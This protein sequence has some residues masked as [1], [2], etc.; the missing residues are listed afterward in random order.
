MRAGRPR[1]VIARRGL[2]LLAAFGFA[3]PAQAGADDI[4][5]L[6]EAHWSGLAAAH[7]RLT[8]HREPGAYRDEIAIV[9]EGLPRLWSKFR[10]TGVSSGRLTAAGPAP[11]RFDADYDLR[12]RKARRLRMV[13]VARSGTIVAERGADDTS[14]KTQLAE[15]FRTSVVDP[16]SALSAIQAALRRGETRFSVPVYDGAR[17]FDA[18]VE[19]QPRDPA[20][21]GARLAMTLKAIAGFKGESSDEGDPDDAP[22]PASLT[23]SDDERLLPLAMT[24]TIWY[25]PLDV[26]LVRTCA[27]AA[28]CSW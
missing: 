19:R 28:E 14:R 7:I 16:L 24:V 27:T 25:L 4:V 23:L 9:A 15:E 11:A 3:W 1:F 5:A 12:K 10:G 21:P 13:F 26:T 20:E 18:I 8:L 2:A 22:R 17:R 6:Y